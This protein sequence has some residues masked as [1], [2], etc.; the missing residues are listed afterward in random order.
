MRVMAFFFQLHFLQNAY[1]GEIG[2]R[3]GHLCHISSFNWDGE[4]DFDSLLD[5]YIC[6]EIELRDDDRRSKKS[7]TEKSEKKLQRVRVR[8]QNV[9]IRIGQ[10]QGC[11]VI[12]RQN[13]E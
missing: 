7:K 9:K 1:V 3:L 12:C 6:S 4:I 8:H 11:A 2:T 10:T 13:M 5:D